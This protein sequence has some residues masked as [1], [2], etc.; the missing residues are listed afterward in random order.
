M[1]A[2]TASPIKKS[3]VKP[4]GLLGSNMKV[5][6]AGAGTS[7]NANKN[8]VNPRESQSNFTHQVSVQI[9]TGGDQSSQMLHG[10]VH[11]NMS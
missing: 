11:D 7:S 8:H 9:N 6:A 5:G 1:E 3:I 10:S 2:G 4:S